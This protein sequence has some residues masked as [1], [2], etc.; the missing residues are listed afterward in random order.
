ML[1]RLHLAREF[2]RQRIHMLLMLQQVL[3]L[4]PHKTQRQHC[5]QQLQMGSELM[6][7]Q[8]DLGFGGSEVLRCL[9][10][11][12][13]LLYNLYNQKLHLVERLLSK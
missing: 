10:C 5:V 7:H 2:E 13:G 4:V 6:H 11:L 8:N 12:K 1:V 3:C 9:G